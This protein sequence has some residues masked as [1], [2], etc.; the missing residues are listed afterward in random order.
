METES[1]C[2]NCR[3]FVCEDCEEY[4]LCIGRNEEQK[5]EFEEDENIKFD[6][7]DDEDEYE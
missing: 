6:T 1:R 5:D 4:H 2:N 3:E 7:E